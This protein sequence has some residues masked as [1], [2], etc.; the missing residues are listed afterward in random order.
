MQKIKLEKRA[1][2][3]LKFLPSKQARQ[4]R[5]KI[6]SLLE[7]TNPPDSKLLQGYPYHRVDVGEYR[8]VYRWDAEFIYV[9]LIGKRND[10]E[11][12][13]KLKRM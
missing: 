3:F 2:K 7:D 11:V 10:S 1:V 4:V 8:I 9:V 5:D 12:Y 6:V 13:R